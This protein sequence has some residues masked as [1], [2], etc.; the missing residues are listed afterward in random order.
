MPVADT[1]FFVDLMRKKSSA[2]N[3]Y[4]SYEMIASIALCHDGILITPDNHFSH[5]PALEVINYNR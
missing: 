5:L 2:I 3:L 1:S 4:T